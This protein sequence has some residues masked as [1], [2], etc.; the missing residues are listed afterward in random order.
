MI[1]YSAPHLSH[2]MFLIAF[3]MRTGQESLSAIPFNRR[4]QLAATGNDP[5]APNLL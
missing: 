1:S 4:E 5:A 3:I 2:V